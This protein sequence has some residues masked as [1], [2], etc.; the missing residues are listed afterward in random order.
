LF[1]RS[2]VS[3]IADR[4]PATDSAP[5]RTWV[6]TWWMRSSS[7]RSIPCTSIRCWPT[8]RACGAYS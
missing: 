7:S 8:S 5:L 1:C 2:A 6:M 4:A 3:L